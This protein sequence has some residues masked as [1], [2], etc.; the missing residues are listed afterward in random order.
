[1][2]EYLRNGYLHYLHAAAPPQ[3]DVQPSRWCNSYALQ[4]RCLQQSQV[5][6]YHQYSC[7]V[8]DEST[9][10]APCMGACL[11]LS[12]KALLQSHVNTWPC[13][14]IHL[15]GEII[16][17]ATVMLYWDKKRWKGP[18]HL[19]E[20]QS[21]EGKTIYNTSIMGSTPFPGLTTRCGVKLRVVSKCAAGR[22]IETITENTELNKNIKTRSR[23]FLSASPTTI[24]LKK[25]L[26]D[27]LYI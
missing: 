26:F 10:T 4:H 11:T 2:L 9:S 25:V 18:S 27:A 8:V 19:S 22:L 23:I 5:R 1:M 3:L 7:P 20:K 17:E 13:Y 24:K 14:H 6:P 12:P 21:E 16:R 15:R